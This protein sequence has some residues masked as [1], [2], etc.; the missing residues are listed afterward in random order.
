LASERH[1]RVR[2]FN[3]DD[4]EALPLVGDVGVIHRWGRREEINRFTGDWYGAKIIAKAVDE[5]LLAVLDDAEND[6][7]AVGIGEGADQLRYSRGGRQYGLVFQL[8]GF[9]LAD[10]LH[11][12]LI[13]VH[14]LIANR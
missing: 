10:A 7:S 5:D 11:D 3:I 14:G 8:F 13:E 9:W 6:G 4:E 12:L 1:R 2:L